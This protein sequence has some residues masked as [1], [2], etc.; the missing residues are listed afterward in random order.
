MMLRV[1]VCG[2]RTYADWDYF[3]WFMDTVFVPMLKGDDFILVQGGA[4]GAD[5]MGK[6]WAKKNGFT[7]EEYG[8]KWDDLEAPGAFVKVRWD[9]KKY[10]A[11]AGLARN[12]HMLNLGIDVLLSFEGG[13]G[14]AHMTGICKKAGVV[15]IRPDKIRKKLEAK[16]SHNEDQREN[17]LSQL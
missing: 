7:W 14:T 16:Y 15:V 11:N 10:N 9:G 5:A 6:R 13:S 1:C 3:Q 12:Q 2:G 17:N 4:T 8:A